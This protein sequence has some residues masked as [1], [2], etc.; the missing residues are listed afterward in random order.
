MTFAPVGTAGFSASN[1]FSITPAHTTDFILMSVVCQN[2]TEYAN[3][4]TSSN[5]TWSVLGTPQLCPA[6]SYYSTVLIGN[7][8]STSP[9]TVTID[10]NTNSPSIRVNYM[11]FS[12]TAGFA[13][14]KLDSL[15]VTIA[16]ATTAYPSITP[17]HGGG[18]LYYCYAYNVSAASA[19]STPGYTYYIDS[20]SNGACWNADCG[21]SAQAPVWADDSARDG[22]AVMLYENTSTT[23]VKPF[24]G[25][26][27]IMP[28][29]IL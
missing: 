19:G 14:V 29:G 9:E 26:L 18:G 2:S 25:Q 12:T 6:S 1:G 17:G 20:Y 11:E 27:P 23:T 13:N 28:E 3:G 8:T 15:A 7:V 4:A 24:L 22:V 10:F 5:A 16:G 21:T